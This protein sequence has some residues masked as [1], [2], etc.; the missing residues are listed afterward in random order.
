V[1]DRSKRF[2][3]FGIEL[4]PTNQFNEGSRQAGRQQRTQE[5]KGKEKGKKGV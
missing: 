3:V 1:R 5:K 2:G 4:Y